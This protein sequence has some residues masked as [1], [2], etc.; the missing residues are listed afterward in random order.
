MPVVVQMSLWWSRCPCG[1]WLL[2]CRTDGALSELGIK[3]VSDLAKWKYA[4]WAQA[5]TV[6]AAYER[7]E[8]GSR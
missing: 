2:S 3:S 8:G 4:K 5:L 1:A 6:L 7:V